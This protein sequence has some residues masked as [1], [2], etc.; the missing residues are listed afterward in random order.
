MT[1]S[2][3]LGVEGVELELSTEPGHDA[4]PSD[5]MMPGTYIAFSQSCLH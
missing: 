1:E 3:E 2:F 5:K 4:T